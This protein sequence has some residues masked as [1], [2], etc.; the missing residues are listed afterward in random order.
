MTFIP[1]RAIRFQTL[2][3]PNE[4]TPVFVATTNLFLKK[5][6]LLILDTLISENKLK[7][8][9]DSGANRFCAPGFCTAIP[10]SVATYNKLFLI[11]FLT[12]TSEANVPSFRKESK[13]V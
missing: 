2:L 7:L 4:Y 1:P 3:S 10:L 13:N 11:E 5:P 8:F 6:I 12:L 9:Q